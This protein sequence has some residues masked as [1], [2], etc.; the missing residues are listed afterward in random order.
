MC[1]V[2]GV[3]VVSLVGLGT[4]PGCVSGPEHVKCEVRKQTREGHVTDMLVMKHT[5]KGLG[6]NK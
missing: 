5:S 3:A 4:V 6:Q 1:G 2:D